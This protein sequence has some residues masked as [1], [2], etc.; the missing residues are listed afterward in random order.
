[1][2]KSLMREITLS[3]QARSGVSAAVLVWMG[4]IALALLT[5]F[6]FL[7]VAA[8]E[9]LSLLY[10]GV[11]AG[12]IMAGI[13]V[14]IAVDRRHR[15]RAGAAPDQGTRH[16]RRARA[17]AHAP[18]WLLDPRILAVAVQAGRSLGWQRI[19]PV[20]LLGFMAAQWARESSRR[21]RQT[22]RFP[23]HGHQHLLD[24]RKCVAGAR[25]ELRAPTRLSSCICRTRLSTEAKSAPRG[26]RR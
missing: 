14:L 20:A 4:V 8:F 6:V 5:A 25:Q 17:K 10:G 18:S 3:V 13:F 15:L 21:R 16:P 26:S 23:K 2:I 24:R 11:I 7:C 12:L 19:V 22:K 1:M 9:W